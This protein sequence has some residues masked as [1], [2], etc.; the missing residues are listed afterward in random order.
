MTLEEKLGQLTQL[1]GAW[2]APGGPKI[3]DR[4]RAMIAEG[5][6][7]SFL[8]VFGADFTRE[9]QTIA[10]DK[11]RLGIPLLFAFDVIHGFRTT[12]PVRLAQASRSAPAHGA[13]AAPHA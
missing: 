6:V 11:S 13:T 3:D 9:L 4:Y 2:D 8:S 7:D 10:V 12:F 1:E 5:K